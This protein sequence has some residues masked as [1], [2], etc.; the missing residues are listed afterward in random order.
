M[1]VSYDAFANKHFTKCCLFSAAAL[2]L[3][4]HS[5]VAQPQERAS[6][7]Q[8]LAVKLSRSLT[9]EAALAQSLF[10]SDRATKTFT[11]ELLKQAEHQL[12][13][14]AEDLKGFQPAA[15]LLD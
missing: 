3:F 2:I 4:S 11:D 6:Q 14:A 1:N 15:L 13:T 12:L 5:C 10:S 7:K 9:T 8:L